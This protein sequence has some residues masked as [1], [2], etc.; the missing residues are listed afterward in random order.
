MSAGFFNQSDAYNDQQLTDVAAQFPGAGSL[1]FSGSLMPFS[2]SFIQETT[3]FR[4]FGPLSGNTMRVVF[5][6]APK[7]GSL[8]SRRTIDVDVRY[9]R[10]LFSTGVLAARFRGFK[11]VG[12]YPDYLFFGGMSEMRGYDYLEFIGQNVV[13]GNVE[14]RFPIVEAM[15]TPIGLLGGV[16]G[17]FFF[18]IGAG[19]YKNQGFQFATSKTETFQ[20][21]TGVELAPDGSLVGIYAPPITVTGFRLRDARASYGVGLETFLLGFPMHFDW[22]W[23]TTFNTSWE[24]AYYGSSAD[25]RKPRFSFWIGYDW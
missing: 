1:N 24:D 11:S 25:W 21:Q 20:Q 4:E 23:R 18:D 7:L 22:A 14:L 16:R 15:L 9:Y 8:M 10:R 13:F 19:W 17:V 2:V 6:Y 5:D 3:V 12:D